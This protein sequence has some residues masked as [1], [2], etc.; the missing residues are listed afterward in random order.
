MRERLN[1]ALGSDFEVLHSLGKGRRAEVFMAREL[2]LD[3]LVAVKVL[4]RN[5]ASD[6]VARAR[7]EREAKAAAS[8][9]HPNAVS[10]YR[11]GFL[12]DGIPYLIMQY[13]RGKTL[14]DRI[15]AEGPLSIPEARRILRDLTDALAAAHQHGF[16][17][18]DIRPGNVMC[19]EESGRTLLTDFGI[20]G[21]LPT[22]KEAGPKLT[23]TGELLGDLQHISPEQLSGDKTTEASDIYSL[24]ILG[25]EI[26]TGEGPYPERPAGGMIA[27][28]LEE[29][30]RRLSHLR[31]GVDPDLENVLANC[32][33]K[34]PRKRPSAEYLG[35]VLS[36]KTAFSSGSHPTAHPESGDVF[37]PL[38]K[39]RLPQ[40]VVVTG[41]ILY[42]V[43]Q[44][45]DMLVD[46]E[47]LPPEAFQL[48]LATCACGV[49]GSGV[50]AWFHGEKGKQ[51]IR[52]FEIGLISL[53]SVIWIALCIWILL[54]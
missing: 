31:D 38:L 51:R 48:A 5:R 44:F 4:H 41:V 29:E 11:F 10:V 20:A 46:R 9:N 22:G 28:H 8:I 33:A 6:E 27:A 21:I 3:R 36:G 32:L 40:I 13:A 24:G 30:P 37:Q 26:L 53:L 17:H 39:K 45:I 23:Q 49:A 14:A 7:F 12:S 52:S 18:R 16:V 42:A 25:Y 47:V 43:L 2:S 34:E 1:E 35:D 50:I 54:G 19:D 15:E